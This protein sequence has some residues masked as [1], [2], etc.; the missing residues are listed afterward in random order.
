M[1]KAKPEEVSLFAKW[2]LS[3]NMLNVLAWLTLAGG[4]LIIFPETFLAGNLINAGLI[5]VIIGFHLKY[6]ENK[7]A[8][9][10]IPFLLMPLLMIYILGI[11]RFNDFVIVSGAK[12]LSAFC[13]TTRGYRSRG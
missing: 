13:T 1:L 2:N 3:K 8:A 7:A 12:D 5:L 4:L 6:K 10:E 11:R 9:M